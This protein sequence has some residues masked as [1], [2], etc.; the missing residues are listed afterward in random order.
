MLYAYNRLEADLAYTST[1][2]TVSMLSLRIRPF[3]TV[4]FTFLYTVKPKA[5][6]ML[7]LIKLI[8]QVLLVGLVMA[9]ASANG[10]VWGTPLRASGNVLIQSKRFGL[11]REE[12]EIKLNATNYEAKVTY[13]L[14]DSVDSANSSTRMYFPVLCNRQDEG[15]S[16]H[17]CINYFKVLINGQ[18]A[19]SSRL[20]HSDVKKSKS[21]YS[22]AAKIN[23]RSRPKNGEL[24]DWEILPNYVFYMI[25]LPPT[26]VKTLVIEY[27]AEYAQ[28]ISGTSK[29]PSTHYS[30]ARMVYDF[31]PAAAWAGNGA[32]ELQIKLDASNMQSPLSFNSQLWPFVFQ[33]RRTGTLTLQQPDFGK[34]PPL[35]FTTMN[36]NYQEFMS[37]IEMLKKS[38][39]RYSVSVIE[40]VKGTVG[41]NDVRALFDRDQTTFWCWKGRDA[42]LLLR[43]DSEAV[44]SEEF[45]RMGAD[46]YFERYLIAIGLLNGAAKNKKSFEEFGMAKNIT[47]HSQDDSL[48]AQTLEKPYLTSKATL[49]LSVMKGDID[50]FRSHELVEDLPFFQKYT[51]ESSSPET[52]QTSSSY[53]KNIKPIE[54]ILKIEDIHKRKTSD[55]SCISE[56]YPVYS[57]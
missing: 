48:A 56:I 41:H 8:T 36:G 27:K 44:I 38:K 15:E 16:A 28:E 47:I 2:L 39:A 5:T 17:R 49:P 31:S 10:G 7:K 29:R 40:V 21:L 43:F 13:F 14:T 1:K 54:F 26:Q 6:D 57:D 23:A 46:N 51:K 33:G 20:T 22:L 19:H 24:E 50:P 42:T 37:M 55:E 32:F 25:E 4:E 52:N 9:D 3:C 45:D 35:E 34:L 11:T 18:S 12:L 53:R 30:P